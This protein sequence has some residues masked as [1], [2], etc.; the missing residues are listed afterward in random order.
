MPRRAPATDPLRPINYRGRQILVLQLRDEPREFPLSD[1]I[2]P[3]PQIDWP[4]VG[5]A[6]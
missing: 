3:S 1:M 4:I 6:C 5:L 2:L